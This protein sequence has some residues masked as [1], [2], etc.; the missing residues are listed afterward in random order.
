VEFQYF[1]NGVFQETVLC[2]CFDL[3]LIFAKRFELGEGDFIL[4]KKQTT[5]SRLLVSLVKF[6]FCFFK[7]LNRDSER[8]V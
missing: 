5:K 3:R 2:F 6:K 7:L 1:R 8:C 4:F